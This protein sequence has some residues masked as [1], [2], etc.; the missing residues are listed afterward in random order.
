MTDGGESHHHRVPPLVL[1]PLPVSLS[2][3]PAPRTPSPP[4]SSGPS[5][6]RSGPPSM[7]PPPI[8]QVITPRSSRLPPAA[9]PPL[10]PAARQQLVDNLAHEQAHKLSSRTC[11]DSTATSQSYETYSELHDEQSG[12]NESDHSVGPSISESQTPRNL[13]EDVIEKETVEDV[14]N[15]GEKNGRKIV[16]SGTINKLVECLADEGDLQGKK[17]FCLPTYLLS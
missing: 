3:I 6:P 15:Y 11:E 4:P 2:L 14:I 1:P 9:P 12:N 13:P 10:S 17:P 16:V 5:T 7:P 8:P